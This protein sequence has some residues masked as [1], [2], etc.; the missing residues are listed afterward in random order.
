MRVSVQVRLPGGSQGQ[1]WR[2]SIYLDRTP[3]DVIVRLTDMEP[4]GET[5]TLRPI[6][7]RIQSLLFVVDTLNTAPGMSG[8]IW[9]RDVRLGVG[10]V[11][12]LTSER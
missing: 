10:A 7:A 6:V 8:T 4:A 12:P 11:E 9:L 2:R 5:T 1:R 3:R